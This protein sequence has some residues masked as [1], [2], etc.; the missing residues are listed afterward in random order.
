MCK[1]FSTTFFKILNQKCYVPYCKGLVN[2]SKYSLHCGQL[3]QLFMEL[4]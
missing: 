4:L 3:F 2:A 1:V